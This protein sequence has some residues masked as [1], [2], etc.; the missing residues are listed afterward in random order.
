MLMTKKK[1]GRDATCKWLDAIPEMSSEP[2]EWFLGPARSSQHWLM[3]T[4]SHYF[5]RIPLFITHSLTLF[6]LGK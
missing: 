6:P 3:P 1:K 4:T 5:I 2:P